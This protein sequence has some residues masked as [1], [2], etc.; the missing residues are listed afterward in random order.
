MGYTYEDFIEALYII[1]KELKGYRRFERL[2]K[3][4]FADT[5]KDSVVINVNGAD[6]YRFSDGR[7]I[8]LNLKPD[9]LL[10]FDTN[11]DKDYYN[12]KIANMADSYDY[13]MTGS[14]IEY[15]NKPGIPFP[16]IMVHIIEFYFHPSYIYMYY[17]E[18]IINELLDFDYERWNDLFDIRYDLRDLKS[19]KVMT[20]SKVKDTD[21]YKIKFKSSGNT[22]QL[23]YFTAPMIRSFSRLGGDN[24]F[25]TKLNSY[26]E[27]FYG[28]EGLT[29]TG[30]M[31]EA[32]L[33]DIYNEAKL[34]RDEILP[35]IER[36]RA[37]IINHYKASQSQ[38]EQELT[39][40]F[41]D[42]L[43]DVMNPVSYYMLY[44]DGKWQ[45]V[46]REAYHSFT[47]GDY[48]NYTYAKY[49]RFQNR[50]IELHLPD[51]SFDNALNYYINN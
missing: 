28:Y 14:F 2:A 40:S 33:I 10:F 21:D 12:K 48:N 3:T 31:L 51:V 30:H 35:E 13:K 8:T 5:D 32:L 6:Y 19:A 20:Y 49:D 1:N 39:G 50:M 27:Q 7:R 17:C 23:K 44:N 16:S 22:Y 9:G 18:N 43:S 24:F 25:R 47:N 34:I 26:K 37:Q 11:I 45:V 46:E 42:Y 41:N 38:I 15:A 29:L 36:A 4:L